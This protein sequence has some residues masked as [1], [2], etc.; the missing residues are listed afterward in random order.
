MR[1]LTRLVVLSLGLGLLVVPATG[2][3]PA[4]GPPL[5]ALRVVRADGGPTRI[6][7]AQGRQVLLRGVNLNSLG[8]YW[9]ANRRYPTVVPAT[10][11]DWDRIA[12]QGFDV[13]RLLVSWSR[14]EPRRGVFDRAYLARV[15]AAVAAAKARGVY[16]VI[17]M[18]QD[19][20]G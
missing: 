5:S 9:Q 8:D 13:V 4:S 17:D 11:A 12:A 20:W 2:A 16:T 3:A 15:R 1:M 18:H 7:D 6:V 19:A 10:D 14:L